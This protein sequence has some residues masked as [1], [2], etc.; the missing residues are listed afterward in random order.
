MFQNKLPLWLVPGLPEALV[1]VEDDVLVGHGDVDDLIS[2]LHRSLNSE[3]NLIKLFSSLITSGP[4]RLECLSCAGL[5]NL[6]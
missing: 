4:N 5:S 2:S 1:V 3:A 6:I